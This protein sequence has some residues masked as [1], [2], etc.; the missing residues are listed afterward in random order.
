MLP[1]RH[2]AKIISITSRKLTLKIERRAAC[3][4]CPAATLCGMGENRVQT[5]SVSVPD[6]QCYHIGDSVNVE[7]N[8]YL[9]W[10]AVI[11]CYV[12]PLLIMLLTLFLCIF[13]KQSEIF[14]G[15]TAIIILIP[16]FF[17]LFLGRKHF[18]KKFTF[19]ITQK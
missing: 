15:I 8:P 16:Y 4:A 13:F 5:F 6:S 12:L 19:N 11:F 14:S 2:E 17:L 1:I 7:L 3:S 10:L 9:G 18:K